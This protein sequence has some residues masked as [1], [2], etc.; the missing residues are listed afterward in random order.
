MELFS[1][2]DGHNL[3]KQIVT[4]LVDALALVERLI[5]K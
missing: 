3:Y 2:I 1:G 4:W 5:R